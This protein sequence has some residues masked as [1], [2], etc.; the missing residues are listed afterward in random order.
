VVRRIFTADYKLS[1]LAEYDRCS[2]PQRG[3]AGDRQQPRSG[4]GVH[5]SHAGFGRNPADSYSGR[6]SSVACRKSRPMPNSS[7]D[8]RHSSSNRCPSPRPRSAGSTYMLMMYPSRCPSSSGRGARA[9][10]SN[11]ITPT[12]LVV[13]A[14]HAYIR[15]AAVSSPMNA[16]VA[17]TNAGSTV[18][19]SPRT[20]F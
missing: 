4:R 20:A 5:S 8:A 12:H 3:T 10:N 11:E 13:S 18:N 16:R 6:L 9:H 14:I 1:V 15:P 17:S 7:L 2:E 19:A